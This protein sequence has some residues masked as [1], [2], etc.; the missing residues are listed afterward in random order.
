MNDSVMT[1][2]YLYQS[3]DIKIEQLITGP[4]GLEQK[5]IIINIHQFDI[6]VNT[7]RLP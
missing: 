1:T 5:L 3:A 7:K 6:S 2:H 4:I